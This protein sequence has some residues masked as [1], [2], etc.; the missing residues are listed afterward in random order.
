MIENFKEKV[1]E[2]VYLADKEILKPDEKLKKYHLSQDILKNISLLDVEAIKKIS[3]NKH[4]FKFFKNQ[5][6]EFIQK[7]YDYKVVLDIPTSLL[8]FIK[9][10]KIFWNYFDFLNEQNAKEIKT[11]VEEF[12]KN[13]QLLKHLY[14]SGINQFWGHI[15]MRYTNFSNHLED[16]F[17]KYAIIE[18]RL[19]NNIIIRYDRLLK[20]NNQEKI[21][22]FIYNNQEDIMIKI[23]ST[24]F[25]TKYKNNIN[26][27]NFND[28]KYNK[29]KH[30]IFS[31]LKKIENNINI[32]KQLPTKLAL[33]YVLEN[34]KDFLCK[35][36][37][38][39]NNYQYEI[40]GIQ[41]IFFNISENK[42][43][44]HLLNT[45]QIQQIENELFNPI[46]KMDDFIETVINIED[47]AYETN[48]C[49]IF[50]Y[51]LKLNK[52]K[53]N[54]KEANLNI[55]YKSIKDNEQAI[56]NKGNDIFFQD[57]VI[58]SFQQTEKETLLKFNDFLKNVEDKNSIS[59]KKDDFLTKRLSKIV[60][61]L[62]K[63]LLD[64]TLK[65]EVVARKKVKL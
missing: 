5:I 7:A 64:K 48:E 43:S 47:F 51:L 42:N 3:K 59:E 63:E 55:I 27:E 34:K 1:E 6:D 62:D 26:I 11:I 15:E 38:E 22:E 44:L 54:E 29:I 17:F 33:D 60:T 9:S 52:L 19:Q 57:W 4:N 21:F 53:E 45:K 36:I 23:L 49:I 2:F 46:I 18:N 32:V 39:N 24:I 50:Y 8:S 40:N 65:N 30:K 20:I 12:Q 56:K 13:P 41:Y 35:M 37:I 16:L 25:F 14:V 61:V 31:Y 58:E 28:E 10:E